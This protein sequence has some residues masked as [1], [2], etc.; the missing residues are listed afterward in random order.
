MAAVAQR[1]VFPFSEALPAAR[2]LWSV[3]QLILRD[4]EPARQGA[5]VTA[6]DQFRGNYADQFQGRIRT[7]AHNATTTAHDLE[8]AAVNIARAWSDA[9]HQQQLYA[10]FA[11]VHDKKNNQSVLDKIGRPGRA[12]PPG[13]RP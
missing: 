13:V 3:A 8:Q 5:A 9:N 7:S 10:Y 12:G 2:Q 4:V 1:V 6:M 11:M